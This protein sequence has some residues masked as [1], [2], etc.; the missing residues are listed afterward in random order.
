MITETEKLF[1]EN[2]ALELGSLKIDATIELER[3]GRSDLIDRVGFRTLRKVDW[4][5]GEDELTL[6]E[7]ACDSINLSH[8]ANSLADIDFLIYVSQNSPTNGI[9][10]FAAKLHKAI[11]G[12]TECLVFDLG[13]GCSGFISAL[14]LCQGIL[15]TLG[16]KGHGIIVTGD[17]YSRTVDVEDVNTYPLFGDGLAVIAVNNIDGPM[18]AS[19]FTHGI[20]SNR[21]RFLQK[22]D[23]GKLEMNGREIVG[24]GLRNVCPIITDYVNQTNKD[25]DY[26]LLH[27]GSKFI[28]ESIINKCQLPTVPGFV[29]QDTGNLVSSTIPA[30]IA[31][32]EKKLSGFGIAAGFGVGL[33]WSI[34]EIERV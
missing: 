4:D 7:K 32:H 12:K 22:K 21:S 33:A 18:I 9:P 30:I 8:S 19:N 25:Y 2:V 6:F 24:M 31:D 5:A 14:S 23:T 34:C 16:R 3:F 20:D 17:L 27:Q 11:G 29:A 26:A 10:H 28:V 13:L 1:I 15:S